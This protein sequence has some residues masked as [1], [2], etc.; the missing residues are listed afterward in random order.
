[1]SAFNLSKAS[2]GQTRVAYG[3][4]KRRWLHGSLKRQAIMMPA[5]SP[6]MTE[7]TITQWKKKEGEAF[8]TGDILLQI[9]SE[10]YTIDVEAQ[11][12]GILGK[13]LMP[14]GTTNVPV[15]QVIALVARDSSELAVLQNQSSVPAPPPFNL[16]PMPPSTS[17]NPASTPNGLSSPR[18]LDQFKLPLSS[19]RTPTM[20]PRTPS[21]FE[22]HTMGHGH[23]SVHMGG[24]RGK[25]PRLEAL[26]NTAERSLDVPPC[27]S[28][29]TPSFSTPLPSTPMTARWPASAGIQRS[30]GLSSSVDEQDI[31]QLDGAALRRMIVS[32]LSSKPAA[33]SVELDEFL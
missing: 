2:A 4:L 15:E 9:E 25:V 17:A 26:P 6:M 16:L 7:G 5:M 21:L 1:M 18:P 29:R 11:S 3:Q 13:I 19:P 30:S 33:K 14:D 32:N 8:A 27:P 24:P 22:M 20:S 12:P 31:P 23:R 28:P 10:Y